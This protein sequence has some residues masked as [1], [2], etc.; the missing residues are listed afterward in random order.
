MDNLEAKYR[1]LLAIIY[2]WCNFYLE[3]A[4]E[5]E[6]KKAIVAHLSVK[7]FIINC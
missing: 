6:R 1:C 3:D 5:T 4:L 2:Y 7:Y